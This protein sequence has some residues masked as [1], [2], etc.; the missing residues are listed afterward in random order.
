MERRLA[1][2][3]AA[4]VVGY[5]RLMEA[6]EEA[7]VRTLSTYRE[8]I[9]DQVTGHHGR[10]FGSAGDSVFVEFTSPVEA[11]RCAVDIQR[12]LE[13]HNTDL[14][15]DRRMHLRIGVNLGDVI[16]EGDNLL[17]DGVNI[18]A[19]LEALAKPGGIALARSVFSHVK[20]QLDLG[21]EYL[22]EHEVKNIAEPVRVY[23]VL[24]EPE[25]VGKVIGEAKQTTQSWI[26]L[27]LAAAVIVVIAVLSASLWLRTWQ[28]TV[29]PA[30]VER[31]T[32]LLPDKPSI[33]VLPFK[34][35][36]NNPEQEYF[37]DGISE[38]IT[39]DLSR[40]SSLFVI[41][42]NSTLAYKGKPVGV[43]EIAR[44]LG[45]RYVLEGSVRK[46]GGQVRITAQLLDASSGA[47]LWAERYDGALADVFAL[48][49][50]VTAKIVAALALRLTANERMQQTRVETVSVAAYDAF[51]RAGRLLNERDWMER[52]D[53]D[54]ARALLE[55]AIELDPNYAAAY[56]SLGFTYWLEVRYPAWAGGPYEIRRARDLAEKAI[57]L[58]GPP[59]AYRLL[60]QIYLFSP[61]QEMRDYDKALAAA[62]TALSLNPNDA[63]SLA[64]LAEVLVFY[65]EPDE[66][67]ALLEKARR[68]NPNFPDWYHRVEGYGYLLKRRYVRAVEEFTPLFEDEGA[69]SYSSNVWLML[70]ASLAHAG[71]IE[72][73]RAVLAPHLT[74]YPSTTLKS[75]ARRLKWFKRQADL[76]IVLDGL[77]KTGIPE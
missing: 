67:L 39:T 10:V 13:A 37:A 25:A 42:R 57:R 29:E 17:G 52:P 75:L 55:K 73:A 1:V 31:I 64:D 45:V 33:A 27:A 70:A 18:A 65:G 28:E 38:D 74:R 6:D 15:E 32:H 69:I 58:D 47:H 77:R 60:A 11:V 76:D 34:N 8:I 3:L 40:I 44:E 72:K 4:D 5:S 35:I 71:Q 19:R 16:V 21:Y 30:A 68:L 14:S 59:Q 20:K 56:A 51:L 54:K 53:N 49:D 43:K 26:K 22:G 46:A 9:D 66:A 7:T 41:A 62:R 24:T 50:T 63:D 36:G 48:Q 23:R 61:W 2:I 12:E